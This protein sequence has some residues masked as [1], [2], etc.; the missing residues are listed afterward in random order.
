M[1]PGQIMLLVFFV[2]CAV[3]IFKI[4]TENKKVKRKIIPR[5]DKPLKPVIETVFKNEPEAENEAEVEKNKYKHWK[6]YYPKFKVLNEGEI[7]LFD[8]LKKAFP[9]K[10]VSTQVSMSQMFYKPDEYQLR[11]IGRKSIDFLVCEKDASMIVAIE[12]NGPHHE[13]QEQIERDII[14][15]EALE[16][17]GI[18][19]LVYYPDKLPSIK[20]IIQ[21][22]QRLK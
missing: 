4:I 12:L 22:V 14:K 8:R 20:K 21:D 11:K 2:L 19:L 5:I 18:P 7:I 17:A 10:L 13:E 3:M 1:K 9:D 15:K 6:K 16:E